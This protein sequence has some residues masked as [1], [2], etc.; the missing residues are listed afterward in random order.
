VIPEE[1]PSAARAATTTEVST[2]GGSS[3]RVTRAEGQEAKDKARA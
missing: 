1:Q 2:Q 3:V